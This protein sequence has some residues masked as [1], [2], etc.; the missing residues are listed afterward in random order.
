MLKNSD[1]LSLVR[2]ETEFNAAVESRIA[3]REVADSVEFRYHALHEMYEHAYNLQRALQK[4]RFHEEAELYAPVYRRLADVQ[5]KTEV[6]YRS[7]EVAYDLAHTAA[8]KSFYAL[9][10]ARE[11]ATI[12]AP[13]TQKA[14]PEITL[15]D[16]S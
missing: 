2:L 15:K 8:R 5:A 6:L 4:N 13:Q 16:I 12:D 7:A 1:L 9:Q 10:E 3:A 14:P 11:S